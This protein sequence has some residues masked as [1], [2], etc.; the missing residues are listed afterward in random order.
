MT[1]T[2]MGKNTFFNSSPIPTGSGTRKPADAKAT[3]EDVVASSGCCAKTKNTLD[4]RDDA[5]RGADGGG[6]WWRAWHDAHSLDELG[7]LCAVQV[8][9]A[10]VRRHP[11]VTL[12][13]PLV[14]L[15]LLVAL[16]VTGVMIGAETEEDNRKETAVSAALD[17]GISF[18]LTVEKVCACETCSEHLYCAGAVHGAWTR[19]CGVV[20]A[21]GKPHTSMGACMLLF[22]QLLCLSLPA[23]GAM[24]QLHGLR[25]CACASHGTE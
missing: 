12:V 24:R 10:V 23:R 6:A 8:V 17:V 13:P 18:K 16:G 5:M 22:V 25:P 7:A 15:V 2:L 21:P 1:R 19:T 4:V 20:H 11:V 3:Q 9:C 14:T